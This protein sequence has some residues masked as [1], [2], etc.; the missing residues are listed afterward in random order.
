VARALPTTNAVQ[1]RPAAASASRLMTVDALRG[2]VM[3][4]MAL[5]HTRDFIH[6]GAMAF[7]PEDLT[8]TTPLLFL[9]RWITHIC[10]PTFMFLAGAGAGLRFEREHD[11]GRLSRF[12][13]T[14][15]LWL[16]VV[17]LTIMRLAMNFSFS[18]A[19]PLL[20]LVLT[21]LGASMIVLAGAIYLP[22]SVLLPVS[23]AVIALH[24][25]LDGVQPGTFGALAPV[26]NLL[27][28][29]GAFSL[30]GA[31]VVVGYPL[32][33]WIAVMATGFCV[34]PVL[35]ANANRRAV[36]LA[37][38]ALCAGFVLL[39]ALNVYGDP[40]PWSAQPSF[41]FTVLSFLRTT[42]YPPSLQ[43]L[44]MTLGPALVVL[45]VI[46]RLPR[47]WQAPLAIIG[48]VPFF[49]YVLH[50]W[51]LHVVASTL[52]WLRYGSSS[53]T[54]LF[55]PLPSM[56]GPRDLFPPGFGY[57]LPVV[58]LVWLGVV[59]GLYPLCRWFS[60][61]KQQRRGEWWVGYL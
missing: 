56:G 37:G 36:L 9:T 15:G 59:L 39:R 7:S 58:Y 38:L 45:S 43:F 60:A 19:N 11:R 28:Q 24:N 13:W 5:D 50:F 54:Y 16:I 44:L 12:L 40:S 18:F 26:W 49:F 1:P 53:L 32:I 8:R 46:D 48:R 29:P 35:A 25:T 21:A 52:A 42:K 2:A 6:A 4:V 51:L 10:A 23:L 34:A 57:S 27:H 14:R 22:R 30:A 20:L 17:E 41:G 3:I 33:P 61:L 55:H 31:I 47:S